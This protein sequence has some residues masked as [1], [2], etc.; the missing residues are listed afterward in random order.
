M[1]L[2]YLLDG[3]KLILQLDLF[4]ILSKI[5]LFIYLLLFD[6]IY[7][8]FFFFFKKIS[9]KRKTT[10]W[11]DPRTK[12]S[13]KG[14]QSIAI[15]KCAEVSLEQLENDEF[16]ETFKKTHAKEDSG[17]ASGDNDDLISLQAKMESM[18]V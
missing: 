18:L 5:Y 1:V 4:I 11:V 2:F 9:H 15:L 14:T 12:R 10:T 16:V 8:L 6:F 17:Y 7:W 3:K 13:Q